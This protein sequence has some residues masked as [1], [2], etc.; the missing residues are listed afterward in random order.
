MT[1]IAE[2]LAIGVSIA[3]TGDTVVLE[4]TSFISVT[5]ISTSAASNSFKIRVYVVP[6]GT[7]SSSQY[8][9]AEID[10]GMSFEAQSGAS[11]IGVGEFYSLIL[12]TSTETEAFCSVFGVPGG[13]T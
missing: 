10:S 12:T 5:R 13:S 2:P 7:D 4:P 9:V 3:A 11:G 6:R 8:L 1:G